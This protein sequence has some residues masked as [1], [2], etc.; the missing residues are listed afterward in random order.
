MADYESAS[1][2]KAGVYEAS[3]LNPNKT[4]RL[5]HTPCGPYPHSLGMMDDGGLV[6]GDETVSGKMGYKFYF[7]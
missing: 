1:A 4:T 2:A 7:K 3:K 6:D 5:N